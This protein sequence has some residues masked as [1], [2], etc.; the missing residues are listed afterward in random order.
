M[1]DRPLVDIGKKGK[2]GCMAVGS[3]RVGMEG[4]ILLAS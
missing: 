3:Q 4:T 2:A 1:E